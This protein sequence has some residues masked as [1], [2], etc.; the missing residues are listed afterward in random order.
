MANGVKCRIVELTFL[1][2]SIGLISGCSAPG[3]PAPV[4]EGERTSETPQA[5]ASAS[6]D[7]ASAIAITGAISERPEPSPS[8]ST[9]P[10]GQ[11]E[12]SLAHHLSTGG[13]PIA[14][15]GECVNLNRGEDGHTSF[16]GVPCNGEHHAQVVG[17][18]DLNDGPNAPAPQLSRLQGLAGE[19]CPILVGEFIGQPLAQRREL[20]V[21]WTGPA[22]REWAGG[23]RTIVCMVSGSAMADGSGTQPLTG[24]MRAGA[25]N[26]A[27]PVAPAPA[28]STQP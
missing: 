11:A 25:V 22:R 18:I 19:H 10:E 23:A 5:W 12:R 21:N 14:Q 7:A 16:A 6:G 28:V 1:V 3:A 20:T 2:S 15:V 8:G 13:Q 24:D 17:F 26:P 27:P 4:V 9:H